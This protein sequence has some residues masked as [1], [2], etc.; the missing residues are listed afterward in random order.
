MLFSRIG[1]VDGGFTTRD[2]AGLSGFDY[3]WHVLDVGLKK[4]I[5]VAVVL[6]VIVNYFIA[7]T[8]H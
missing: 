3:R 2:Q 5:A 7:I 1:L 6:A 4:V 8:E